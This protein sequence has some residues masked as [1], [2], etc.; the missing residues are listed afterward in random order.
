MTEKRPD[1]K[2]RILQ[3]HPQYELKLGGATYAGKSSKIEAEIR[4]C[5]F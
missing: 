3:V 4:K 1:L 2:F 5:R